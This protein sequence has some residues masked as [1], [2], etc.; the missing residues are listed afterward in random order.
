M[1]VMG[2]DMLQLP[3]RLYSCR[4]TIRQIWNPRDPLFNSE[5]ADCVSKCPEL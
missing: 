1:V 5:L 3:C 2:R 4:R